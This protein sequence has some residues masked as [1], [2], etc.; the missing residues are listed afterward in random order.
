MSGSGRSGAMLNQIV[1]L[2]AF[3]QRR[4]YARRIAG[5]TSSAVPEPSQALSTAQPV[6]LGVVLEL[7]GALLASVVSWAASRTS[8][9]SRATEVRN[10]ASASVGLGLVGDHARAPVTSS[11]RLGSERRIGLGERDDLDGVGDRRGAPCSQVI[12]SSKS[13]RGKAVHGGRGECRATAGSEVEAGRP[14][15]RSQAPPRARPSRGRCSARRRRGPARRSAVTTSIASTYYRGP[16][17]PRQFQPCPPC[18]RKPPMPTVGQCP[19]G[20]SA[21]LRRT[22]PSSV[23][24]WHAGEAVTMP[25]TSSYAARGGSEVDDQRVGADRP[26]RPAVA[27]GPDRH[28]PA[29]LAGQ[30]DAEH[31]VRSRW[32]RGP[33]RPT[34][35]RSAVG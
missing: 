15:P 21:A 4:L 23:P 35:G 7:A 9:R 17:Q 14:T 10:G 29:P 8:A 26:L 12:T 18:S 3:G 2:F 19:P 25:V 34:R 1:K 16:A 33:R 30:P 11:D 6:A 32:P 24:P 5:T 31:D 13:S 27:A 20:K 28:L 22:A